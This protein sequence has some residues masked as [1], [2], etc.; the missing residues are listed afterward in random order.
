MI[1]KK[2]FSFV[3]LI[4]AS[5]ILVLLAIVW[6]SINSNSL[7][8]K[9]NT[10]VETDLKTIENA[11]V[12]YIQENNEL[13]M[14]E[15]NT[16]FI[17]KNWNYSHSYE[18]EDT[19]SVYWSFTEKTL[20][21][22]YL[23][24]TPLDPRTNSYY[25]YAKIS[26]KYNL[27]QFEV[28]WVEEIEN[29]Q[30]AKVIWNYTAE[31]WPY[32]LI[33]SYNSSYFV[34]DKWI[35]LP[36]NPDDLIL[37]AT[38]SDWVIYREWDSVSS[39]ID[40]KELFFSDWSVSVL[41]PNSNIVLNKLNFPKENNLVTEIK[42][43]LEAG[44][45]WTKATKLDEDS[46]FE[47][48]TADSAAAVRWTI[49]WV[50]NKSVT[51]VIVIEWTVDVSKKQEQESKEI[52]VWK[53]EEPKAIN[54]RD[55]NNPENIV[56]WNE[57]IEFLEILLNSSID[58]RW[59]NIVAN[60]ENID[61]KIDNHIKKDLINWSDKIIDTE[62][63]TLLEEDSCDSGTI[64]FN[65]ECIEDTLEDDDWE[66]Y[67]FAWFDEVWNLDMKSI[68]SI[69]VESSHIL[70]QSNW[71]V[72][73]F[74]TFC[75]ES[76]EDHKKISFCDY[77]Y[78][79]WIYIDSWCNQEWEH[80]KPATP[81]YLLYSN[82][83]LNDDFIIEM[84]VRIPNDSAKH[85]L[86]SNWNLN[87]YTQGWKLKYNNWE[88]TSSNIL[89]LEKEVFNRI[90]LKKWEDNHIMI[91]HSY[92]KHPYIH[93]IDT[94]KEF[95]EILNYFYVWWTYVSDMDKYAFQINNIIDYVKIYTK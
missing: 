3:E 76:T 11:L 57:D 51:E 34:T 71:F 47:I 17:N 9:D 80:C 43:F 18:N 28:A 93:W 74:D 14:P 73:S 44:A 84:N 41:E 87:L 68:Q 82:L 30:K 88:S 22:K 20:A 78:W 45:I 31:H 70:N 8:K 53:S 12:W 33:K 5:S 95:F 65:W 75:K 62:E 64:L 94:Q 21:K 10:K 63:D 67:W 81:D 85:Y 26:E 40:T 60:L 52:N 1:N 90:F 13:P 50:K 19:F 2:A 59:E 23:D 83:N 58:Q 4:I 15:W 92:P 7:S 77:W 69:E 42:I 25:S 86:L 32:N 38:D 56:L 89:T 55:F 24:I 66:L 27:N 91:W 35:Y 6:Y 54:I 37:I 29:N 16:N 49:F 61:R 46:M 36:Y 39:W 79:K 72:N 48:H